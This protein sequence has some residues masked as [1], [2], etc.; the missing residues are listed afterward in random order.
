M[1]VFETVRENVTAIDVVTMAGIKPNRSKMICCPF[2][3]DKR[4]SMKVDNQYYCFGCGAKGDAIDFVANY[5][6]LGLKAAAE[7]IATD[8]VLAYDDKRYSENIQKKIIPKKSEY[9]IWAERKRE[10]FANLSRLHEKL[11]QMKIKYEPKLREDSDWS[12][13]FSLAVKDFTYVDYLYDYCMFEA[14]ED[15]LKKEYEEIVKEFK[16]IEKRINDTESGAGG[17]DVRQI[18][19]GLAV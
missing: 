17:S 8:F 12:P 1:N 13:L 16:K 15:E 3:N 9:Q 19:E 11:R 14:T 10:L 5:Y 2:H 7:K 6:G 18:G 4:P